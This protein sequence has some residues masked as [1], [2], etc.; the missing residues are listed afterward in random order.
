M[1]YKKGVDL[2]VGGVEEDIKKRGK[3][4]CIQ[5]ILYEKNI[6]H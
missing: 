6:V 1:S 2:D 3:R 4:I 5:H